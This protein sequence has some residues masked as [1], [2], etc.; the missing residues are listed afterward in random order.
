MVGGSAM[1]GS[2]NIILER[3]RQALKKEDSGTTDDILTLPDIERSYEQQSNLSDEQKLHLFAERVNEYRAI[4]EVID[5]EEIGERIQSICSVSGIKS[6]AVPGGIEEKWVSAL[7]SGVRLLR[8]EPEPL[9]KEELNNAAAVLTGAFLGVAQTGTIILN[10][11]PG[12]GRRI[13]TLLPDFH[14][15]VIRQEQIT[16]ILPEA[17]IQLD[18]AVKESG[19]PVTMISGPSATSDIELNRVEGVHGPRRLHVLVIKQK[20]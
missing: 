14:I 9:T 5:E 4:T 8:D 12:Q 16:G 13:L 17:I 11:G 1:S 18:M 7:D 15:C 10:G 6:L 19:K 20:S 3:I 2:K